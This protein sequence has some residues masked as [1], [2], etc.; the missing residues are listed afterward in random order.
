M[1]NR[2]GRC[3]GLTGKGEMEHPGSL[4]SD[5]SSSHIIYFQRPKEDESGFSWVF[6]Q[7]HHAEEG[8]HHHRGP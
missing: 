2:D 6:L 7:V 5:S 8:S 4:L 3:E 1:E